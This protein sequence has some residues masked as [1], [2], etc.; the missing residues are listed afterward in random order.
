MKSTAIVIL[1]YNDYK[2]TLEMINNI[3]NFDCLNYIIIVDNCSTD[4]SVEQ[5][6]P[7]CNE[8]IILLKA[9]S[10]RGYAAGNNIGCKYAAEKLNVQN[11]I[12]SNPD[13]ICSEEDMQK[14]ID[15]LNSD[16]AMAT[17]VIYNRDKSGKYKIFSSFGWRVPM[18]KDLLTN[19]FLILYKLKRTRNRGIYFNYNELKNNKYLRVEAVPGCFFAIKSDVL[20]D[21]D[22]FD[23]RTFLYYEENIL[24]YKLKAENYKVII[25]TDAKVYHCEN[26]YKN[27]NLK[28]RMFTYRKTL[29]SADVYM[30]Y[31]LNKNKIFI[32][33]FHMCF[34]L[35]RIEGYILKKI[36]RV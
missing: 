27:N 10:N 21:I 12:V 25:C 29:N 19:C 9:E 34:W 18:Y 31:Y 36:K 20:K 14:V 17:G 4:K 23:E 13:I 22:Y 30:R 6:E 28:K 15:T 16:T 24:G 5:I 3:K 8:K 33:L 1:N 11:V 32:A 35:G 26:V 7:I 2:V